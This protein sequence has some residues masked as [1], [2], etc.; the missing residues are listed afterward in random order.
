MC[1]LWGRLLAHLSAADPDVD[2]AE[3]AQILKVNRNAIIIAGSDRRNSKQDI[4]ATKRRITSEIES[5]RGMAWVTAGKEIENYIPTELLSAL[6]PK[7][8]LNPLTRY[9]DFEK[10]VDSTEPGAGKVYRRNKVLFAERVCPHLT[11]EML[12]S[13]LD[14]SSQLAETYKHIR[15]WNG[16]K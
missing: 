5:I 12:A 7:A 16:N 8:K 10:H 2:P 3:V 13:T 9:Q 1:L 15:R 6:F 14:L 11:K 4:S